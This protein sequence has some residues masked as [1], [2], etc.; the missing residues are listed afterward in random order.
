MAGNLTARKVETAKPGK[1]SDGGN[2]YL[3]VS[4]GGSRKWVL[5]FTWRGRPKEMGLG[6]A[7]SVSLADAREKAASARRRIAQGINP[8]EERK[9]D[10]G[11]PTFGEMAD[12][13][14]EALAAGF[15]NEAQSPVE[16]DAGNLRRPVAGQAGGHHHDG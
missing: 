1:Y 4:P 8:I 14:R 2:L 12:T 13:V 6:S 9:R 11:I 5:R 3:A 16:N 15:R 10:S 7:G